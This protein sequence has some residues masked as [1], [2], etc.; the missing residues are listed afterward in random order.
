MDVAPP[1]QFD[2]DGKPARHL[3]RLAAVLALEGMADRLL[4]GG[5]LAVRE[6]HRLHRQGG[7]EIGGF[8]P[9]CLVDIGI[10]DG[11]VVAMQVQHQFGAERHV[12]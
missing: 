8:R 12:Q 3:G 11:F 4:E 10:L 2:G 7:G 6:E 1:A 9:E 5:A